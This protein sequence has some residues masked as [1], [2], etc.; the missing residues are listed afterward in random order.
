ML[1]LDA[2]ISQQILDSLPLGIYV[3]TLDR[4]ILFWNKAAE[5]I[6]GY[7]AQDVNGNSCDDDVL[8]HSDML[9]MPVCS[10]PERLLACAMGSEQSAETA[11]F[12]RHKDGHHFAVQVRSIPLRGDNGKVLAIAEVF[13]P[14]EEDDGAL[15]HAQ[16]RSAPEAADPLGILSVTDSEEY[17]ETRMQAAGAACAVYVMEVVGIHDMARQRGLE[18]VHACVRQLVHHLGIVLPMP[19]FLGHWQDQGFL[20]VLPHCT[21]AEFDDLLEILGGPNGAVT[22][23]WWGDRVTVNV[24]VRGAMVHDRESLQRLMSGE[25]CHAPEETR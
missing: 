4:H 1:S 9:A 21:A 20:I 12:A 11:L 2:E 23:L 17:L 15:S 16:S 10:T 5:R 6:T 19:H 22:L 7:R 8:M 14:H 24:K 18:M 25:G 13:E 3:V